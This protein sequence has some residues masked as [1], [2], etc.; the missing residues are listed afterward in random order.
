MNKAKHLFNNNI[1]LLKEKNLSLATLIENKITD[2]ITIQETKTDNITASINNTLLHSKYNPLKE[3]ANFPVLNKIKNGDKVMLYGFGFGYHILPI[4][5]T[6]G[7]AGTLVIVEC[8]LNILNAAFSLID[9]SALFS[10]N[11]WSIITAKEELQIA[12]LLEETLKNNFTDVP[13]ANKKII[14][15]PPSFKCIPDKFPKIKNAMEMLSIGK[16][17]AFVFKDIMIDNLNKNL[18]IFLSSPGIKQLYNKMEGYPVFLVGAGPSL[19][20]TISFLFTHQ[21]NAFIAC[22]DTVFPILCDYGIQPDIVFSVDPQTT[23]FIHFK[24]NLNN[25]A[26]LIFSP[27]SAPAIVSR[28]NGPKMTFIKKDQP[29]MNP[30]INDLS[31]KGFSIGGGSVSCIALDILTS[32]SPSE[33][34]FMGMDFSFPH[35][36]AY[37]RHAREIKNITSKTEKFLTPEMIHRNIIRNKNIIYLDDKNS[38]KVASHQN[39]HSYVKNIEQIIRLNPKINYVNFLSNGVKIKG[40]KYIYFSEELNKC[41]KDKINKSIIRKQRKK[42]SIDIDIKEKILADIILKNKQ[43]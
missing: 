29:L 36:K 4:L 40:S 8:N 16:D 18:D 23:S 9:L 27:V 19:D 6:I 31:Y 33:I 1:S 38:S 30:V 5:E 28:Y 14:I 22:V 41:L 11:N 17:T 12:G 26:L 7:E 32:F 37:S 20:D 3:A 24:E 15:H 2:D 34:I 25:R 10:Y 43:K 21:D 39:M 13:S 35:L 42:D